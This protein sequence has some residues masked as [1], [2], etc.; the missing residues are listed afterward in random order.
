MLIDAA[1]QRIGALR[2]TH[3]HS[4]E[5]VASIE[6][7]GDRGQRE[8]TCRAVPFRIPSRPRHRVVKGRKNSGALGPFARMV[9]GEATTAVVTHASGVGSRVEACLWFAPRARCLRESC[10]GRAKRWHVHH[11]VKAVANTGSVAPAGGVQRR[12]RS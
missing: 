6:A 8:G 9:T 4:I 2:S 5:L 11:V 10:R 12:E 1:S 3:Y 7:I